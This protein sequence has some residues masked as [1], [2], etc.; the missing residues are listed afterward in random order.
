MRT[1]VVFLGLMEA[2]VSSVGPVVA[3][4]RPSH[5]NWS[6]PSDPSTQT[7]HWRTVP[8]FDGR[9]RKAS[10]RDLSESRVGCARPPLDVEQDCRTK[11]SSTLALGSVPSAIPK[12]RVARLAPPRGR[13]RV[14]G[15]RC[16]CAARA[17]GARCGRLGR[18]VRP[19]GGTDA[20]RESVSVAVS[21]PLWQVPGGGGGGGEGDHH[22]RNGARLP[23]RGEGV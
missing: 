1:K 17:R 22:R 12:G 4:V 15:R 10:G 5:A 6:D 19:R 14:D 13:I 16:G 9:E 20:G 18:G 7:G 8:L 23:V 11:A 2:Q 3:V 21:V